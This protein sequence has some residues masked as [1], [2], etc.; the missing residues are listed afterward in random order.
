MKNLYRL[1]ALTSF[2]LAPA[3]PAQAQTPTL[4]PGQVFEVTVDPGQMLNAQ[5]VLV[6][7]PEANVAFEYRLGSNSTPVAA[8]KRSP[9]TTGAGGSVLV[10]HIVPPALTAG[11]QVIAFRSKTN[12]AE[13]GINPS[14]WSAPFGFTVAIVTPTG[15]PGAIRVLSLP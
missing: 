12:P 9:C 5:G 15:V 4:T 11:P 1:L 14:D 7:R 13:A 3:L 8:T 6:T 10:C 2:L